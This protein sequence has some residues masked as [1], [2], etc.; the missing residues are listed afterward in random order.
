MILTDMKSG[1]LNVLY[2]TPLMKSDKISVMIAR[3]VL[4]ILLVAST[5]SCDTDCRKLNHFSE[6]T[7]SDQLQLVDVDQTTYKAIENLFLQN[8]NFSNV[9]RGKDA[10]G[11]SFNHVEVIDIKKNV[12]LSMESYNKK[13]REIKNIKNISPVTSEVATSI[14]LS[15][16]LS[17]QLS[18]EANEY[19]LFHGTKCSSVNCILTQGFNVSYCKYTMLGQGLYFAEKAMKS[20]Q[21]SDPR[22]NRTSLGTNLT[23]ILARVILGPYFACNKP[24][25][26]QP[27]PPCESL[28]YNATSLVY[29]A[30]WSLFREF[31][32]YDDSQAFPAY[33]ITYVRGNQPVTKWS[34]MTWTQYALSS[35]AGTLLYKFLNK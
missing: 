33:V 30:S 3:S 4:A 19:F 22:D 20:D 23:M 13:L 26:L 24:N 14:N 7:A 29:E 11:I 8:W 32:V 6:V 35:C 15:P 16:V 31:V 9:G 2:I 25:C 27:F 1:I 12:H 34:L 5:G 18:A 10:K 28:P 17:S 21:Y